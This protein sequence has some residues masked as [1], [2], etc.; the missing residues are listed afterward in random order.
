MKDFDKFMYEIPLSPYSMIFYN[1]WKLN[2][3]RSDYNIIFNQEL[4]GNLD[5]DRLDKAIKRLISENI[6][7]NSHVVTKDIRSVFWVP[8]DLITG[9]NYNNKNIN[10]LSQEEPFD[11]EKGPLYRFNLIKNADLSY[12]FVIV[13]HHLLIDGST[14][15]HFCSELSKYYNNEEYKNCISIEEQIHRNIEF[16][17]KSSLYINAFKKESIKFFRENLSD[18]EIVD[19]N[20]LKNSTKIRNSKEINEIKFNFDQE[21][22]LKLNSIKKKVISPFFYGRAIFSLLIYKY[23]GQKKFCINY[24]IAIREGIDFI[25]GGQVNTNILPVNFD[26]IENFL[27][28]IC[29]A[30]E[31]IKSQKNKELNHAYL[32]LYEIDFLNKGLLNFSFSQTTLRDIPF[33]FNGVKAIIK[34][35]PNIDLLGEVLFEHGIK[36]DSINYIVRYKSNIIDKIL[37]EEFI[38]SFKKLFIEILNELISTESDELSLIKDYCLLTQNQYNK[39]IYEWNK[40]ENYYPGNKTLHKLFEEQVSKTPNSIAVVYK[41]TKMTYKELNEKANQLAHYLSKNYSIKPDDIIALMLD[42]SEF[43]IV[44]I[45]AVLKAGGAYVPVDPSHPE[46]RVDYIF[47]DTLA[48]VV[49]VD[50]SNEKKCLELVT[51]DKVVIIGNDFTTE[52]SNLKDIQVESSNLAYVIYT[53]GTT[54][55]PKG[56]MIEHKTAV[57]LLFQKELK[58]CFK[59]KKSGTLWT[60]ISFDVSVYEIFSLLLNGST[61]HVLPN[62]VREDVFKFF[63][64]IEKNQI[65]YA[66]IPPYY[67]S[68]YNNKNKFDFIL[69][70]VDKVSFKDALPLMSEDTIILNGYGP[71][72]TT[73][74]CTNY[75]YNQ[76]DEQL[77]EYLPIGVPISNAKCYVLDRDFNPLP[78]G[79]I[80]ELF[81]GGEVLARGYINR[82]D[83][84][85]ERFIDNKFQNQDEVD[86]G[87]NKKLYGTGDLVRWLPNQKLQYIG[88]NDSQIKLRGYR[89]ELKEIENVLSSYYGI[90]QSIVLIKELP[91]KHLVAYYIANK[92]LDERKI[93]DYL[94]SKLPIY[95][96][97]SYILRISK[98]P[99]TPNGKVDLKFLSEPNF[100]DVKGYIAPR[101]EFE[102]KLCN[103]WSEILKID[104]SKIGITDNFFGM[105]GNSILAIKLTSKINKLLNINLSV[106]EVLKNDTIVKLS[107]HINN[108]SN[109]QKAQILINKINVKNQ[110]E[111]L[112]SFAQERMLFIDK[113]EN[114]S[115]VNNIPL[116]F[117]L[118]DNV[119]FKFLEK[120][121][122]SV[123]ERHEILRT[124]IKESLSGNYYQMVLSS[125][126]YL[127]KLNIIDLR[128]LKELNRELCNIAN[129]VFDLKN[130]IPIRASLFKLSNLE[131]Y[132]CILLHHIAFDGWSYDIFINEIEAFYSYFLNKASFTLPQLAIQYKDFALWQRSFLSEN[133]LTELLNYWKE[134][135]H[136]YEALHLLSD[137]PRPYTISYRG[138]DEHFIVSKHISN[139][140]REL[141]KELNVSLYC[142]LLSAYCLILRIYSNQDDIV[143]GTPIANRN[144]SETENLIG[145]F[146]NSL[147]IRIII[148]P[149]D[150]VSSLINQVSTE[151]YDAFLYQDL[152]FEKLVEEL[153]FAKDI[154]RHPIFQ[155]MF[156]LQR[157]EKKSASILNNYETNEEFFKVA[158]FDLSTFIDDSEDN[159]KGIFNYAT[160]LYNRTTI[161][162]FIKLYIKILEQFAD[163]ANYKEK[164]KQFKIEDLE[165]VDIKEDDFILSNCKVEEHLVL[166]GTIIELFEEQVTM[167]PNNIAIKCEGGQL[168]YKQLSSKVNELASYLIDEVKV[169]PENLVAIILDRSEYIIIAILAILKTG[170]AYVP[171]DLGYPDERI[172]YQV[173]DAGVITI[174]TNSR[175]KEKLENILYKADS[176]NR[177]SIISIDKKLKQNIAFKINQDPF[178]PTSSNLAYLLY[179]SGTTGKPKGVMVEHKSF[180]AL[181]KSIKNRYFNNKK[182]INTFSITN[183]VFDIFGLEYGLPLLTGG[184]ITIG[185]NQFSKLDCSE[186]DFIQMTPSLCELKLSCLE[187]A[188]TTLLLIGGENLS[189]NLL[190]KLLNKNIS[191]INVYGPTEATIWSTSKLYIPSDISNLE[192]VSIGKPLDGEYAYILDQDMKIL[193][194]GAIGELYIGGIGLAR[195]YLNKPELT[196]EKFI[197]N[198]YQT[199]EEKNK[200]RNDRLYKTGD[201]V[202][203][204]P[205]GEIQYIG[206][207][208]LQ[209]K[210]KGH[211][212][213]LEE[214]ENTI[215]SHNK[216]KNT[217]VIVKEYSNGKRLI[218]FYTADCEIK[219][220][221]IVDYLREYLSMYALP[222]RMIY[223]DSL[224]L[225]VNGKLDRNSLKNLP[226]PTLS[227]KND[228]NLVDNKYEEIFLSI[229]TKLLNKKEIDINDNFFDLGGNSLLLTQMHLQLPDEIKSKI[230]IMNLFQYT[231]IA[232]L[233]KFLEKT[234]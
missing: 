106:A 140:V 14:I 11:I 145:L 29:Q 84:T 224:P 179:T 37:L 62:A 75:I 156:G 44:G 165:Y 26:K 61:L 127:F 199:Q 149:K 141:A 50:K 131:N 221:D 65:N 192:V 117:K 177:A 35:E 230:K 104:F 22:L 176:K 54:G 2:P 173:Q 86:S 119:D 45:L 67:V 139:K 115:S 229:W 137:K 194:E 32:P 124:L 112:L 72:E 51:A 234:N 59:P 92:K 232:K 49:I 33:N 217:A 144:N 55:V 89:V 79:A 101:N 187:K 78:V 100:A 12:T 198:P 233:C 203:R 120:S 24:P 222:D 231:T 164:Q 13:L 56:V 223:M 180:I 190:A 23:T 182:A 136:G 202:K 118:S 76:K 225:T 210:I 162:N 102:T 185:D 69:L 172:K 214:I 3:N 52:N 90:K 212:I 57:N 63:D 150:L 91:N 20:F 48:K 169:R 71:T 21:V 121:I 171:I 113:Y 46:D 123:I 207:N 209:I 41:N 189:N 53:S 109:F 5:I 47:K 125:N 155:V 175:N 184:T 191:L 215:L 81:I 103:L 116:V 8:N 64:Y 99:L 27:D 201:L 34:N 42:R 96:I 40:T 95:M 211:R 98:I 77:L 122:N 30:K 130:E 66:Y 60:N 193:P 157:I 163:I 6:I 58:N 133:K 216:I 146:V 43:L 107:L 70:G 142:V 170:C 19:F 87:K 204:L 158:K 178:K 219:E 36:D 186:Y 82:Q 168:T 153:N 183:Y 220:D 195:G 93:F 167:T 16:S 80:G 154:S 228:Y 205:N 152:P 97:P 111:Q 114:G 17:T 74:F 25:F 226:I 174:L 206:R 73:V 85:D 188:S 132:L 160:D 39:I 197:V 166:E 68:E 161:L 110:E 213:E 218:G 83:L 94:V 181:I 138:E 148:N 105:G 18:V 126:E 4:D 128:D 38:T 1:E 143:L 208:D 9:I 200:N 88:R 159:I 227:N 28:I 15:D 7:F 129:R 151:I 108:I 135:L 134:K 147:V 31:F 10:S 196:Q